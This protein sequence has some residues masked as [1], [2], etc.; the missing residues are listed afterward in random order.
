MDGRNVENLV[1]GRHETAWRNGNKI[2]SVQ[3]RERG[4]DGLEAED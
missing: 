1:E 3:E 2:G 4:V